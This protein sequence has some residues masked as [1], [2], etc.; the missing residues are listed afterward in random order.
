[1]G[2]CCCLPVASRQSRRR[3][4]RAD[5]G[6]PNAGVG[7]G[8]GAW[9]WA[10][11]VR[12]P[13]ASPRPAPPGPGAANLVRRLM[14]AGEIPAAGW[15]GTRPLR[16]PSHPHVQ[17][18]WPDC[19]IGGSFLVTLKAGGI[20]AAGGERGEPRRAAG[21]LAG[22]VAGA[23]GARSPRAGAETRR[24]D[25]GPRGSASVGRGGLGLITP[26]PLQQ[27]LVE[28]GCH[29]PSAKSQ[30]KPSLSTFLILSAVQVGYD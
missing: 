24:G 26:F 17:S 8:E 11:P 22:R 13:G 5:R 30:L 18:P 14:R 29:Q 7:G 1:M 2:S 12:R 21:R 16:T 25:E 27:E 23:L 19:Q 3:R 6:F 10:W 28:A 4:R 15:R 20:R 9:Q